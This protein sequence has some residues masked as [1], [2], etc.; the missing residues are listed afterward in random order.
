VVRKAENEGGERRLR[1]PLGRA[2]RLASEPVEEV[3]GRARIRPLRPANDN[4]PRFR[5]LGTIAK[6]AV[7]ATVAALGGLI[8]GLMLH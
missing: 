3:A 6:P 2:R 1:A 7:I 4:Q 5:V 8:A